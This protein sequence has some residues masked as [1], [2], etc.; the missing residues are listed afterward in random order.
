MGVVLTKLSARRSS[1]DALLV[2]GREVEQV[3]LGDE[4]RR[5]TRAGRP[6][7][8]RARAARATSPA[9]CAPP[10]RRARSPTRSP[11]CRTRAA[12]ASSRRGVLDEPVDA[13]RR[14]PRRTARP[15][16]MTA[17]SMSAAEGRRG[18]RATAA[19]RDTRARSTRRLGLALRRPRRARRPTA[20]A[21]A[22]ASSSARSRR[23]SGATSK[24]L[25]ARRRP[26]GVAD[27]Q[28]GVR[29]R[30]GARRQ[31]AARGRGRRARSSPGRCRGRRAR[32]RR[33][34]RR[35]RS[36]IVTTA[37]PGAPVTGSAPEHAAGDVVERRQH[38]GEPR[39]H[40]RLGD[41]ARRGRR[42]AGRRRA[43][44]VQADAVGQDR[45]RSSACGRRRARAGSCRSC[46]SSAS[47]A[48]RS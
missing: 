24:T 2:G 38:A 31:H 29:A 47:P 19:T 13:G 7:G 21:A 1:D 48:A 23:T 34:G 15:A 42:P 33:A 37:S 4:P 45:R 22:R 39:V 41:R 6:S 12:R 43:V 36:A 26:L 10:A 16:A 14:R 44:Q 25:T 40:R 32:G 17:S 18:R 20:A 30:D 3:V 9:Y 27:L 28:R 11:G 35:P 5:R 8:R 46:T